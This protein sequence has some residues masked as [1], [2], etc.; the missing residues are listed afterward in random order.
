MD[1]SF[2]FRKP[3]TCSNVR[4]D[5]TEGITG[6]SSTSEA[7]KMFSDSRVRLGGQSAKMVS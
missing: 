5:R 4:L 7:L 1:I 6:M 2:F 3:R